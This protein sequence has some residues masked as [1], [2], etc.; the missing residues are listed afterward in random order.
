MGGRTLSYYWNGQTLLLASRATTLLHHPLVSPELNDL[1]V[2]HTLNIS[3][4]HPPGITVFREI[5]RLLPGHALV[6]HRGNLKQ[7][8]I[9][10]LK[11]P[12]QFRKLINLQKSATKNFGKILNSVTK[13]RLRT[14]QR[15]GTY[16]TGGL[17][18]TT[19]TLSLLNQLPKD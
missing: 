2:A 11:Q 18:S 4:G 16:L 10:S 14:E 6:L 7:F 19:V 3:D 13:D 17:D 8:S 15:V 5:N 9:D 1:Y 12:P